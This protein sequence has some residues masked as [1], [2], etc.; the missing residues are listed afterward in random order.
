MKEKRLLLVPTKNSVGFILDNLF[1]EKT[2]P[3]DGLL[4]LFII[5]LIIGVRGWVHTY[6]FP[7]PSEIYH[8]RKEM[9]F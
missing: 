4:V 8:T 2:I 7:P 3:N 5:I 6:H 1:N 9:D